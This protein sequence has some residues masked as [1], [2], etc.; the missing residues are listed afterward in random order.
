MFLLEI[1][2]WF[3]LQ[4]SMRTAG[5]KEMFRICKI[6]CHPQTRYSHPGEEATEVW[7]IAN[8]IITGYLDGGEENISR[9]TVSSQKVAVE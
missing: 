6:E 8:Y 2:K 4:F 3:A 1:S 7:S 9:L 5:M